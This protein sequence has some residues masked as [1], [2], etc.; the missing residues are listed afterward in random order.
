MFLCSP[1]SVFISTCCHSLGVYFVTQG[2][3]K[4]SRFNINILPDTH[5]MLCLRSFP[6]AG[7]EEGCSW[8]VTQ[9]V[10]IWLRRNF[11][12]KDSDNE[13]RCFSH[14]Q[15]AFVHCCVLSTE[16]FSLYLSRLWV[17]LLLR[18]KLHTDWFMDWSH[19]HFLVTGYLRCAGGKPKTVFFKQTVSLWNTSWS[20][21]DAADPMSCWDQMLLRHLSV[22][23]KWCRWN[24][25]W[26]KYRCHRMTCIHAW[27]AVHYWGSSIGEKISLIPSFIYKAQT[28]HHPTLDLLCFM[29]RLTHPGAAIHFTV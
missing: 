18:L 29:L 21:R 12:I 4:N 10:N 17:S 8:S 23:Y 15:A 24:N 3:L 22:S 28:T 14:T 25:S 7:R 5:E 1:T 11:T 20:I 6:V 16:A 26:F 9:T 2:F 19:A 27:P 13:T